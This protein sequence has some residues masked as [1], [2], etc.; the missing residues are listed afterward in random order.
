MSELEDLLTQAY[1]DEMESLMNYL[2]IGNNLETFD[3]VDLGE[4][5][6]AD[7]DEELDHAKAIAE[8]LDVMGV[9]VPGSFDFAP[10]QEELQPLEDH[11]DV[12]SVLKGSIKAEKE[13]Q[14]LYREI[15]ELAFEQGDHPTYQL[16]V[17]HLEDEEHH[18][19]EMEDLL[20]EFEH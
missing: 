4:E 19:S 5:L 8:R 12:V 14:E 16:A 15:A 20:V 7:V 1:Y 10:H 17:E 3:G 6:L 13:A 2:A 9:H 11:S 18:Q